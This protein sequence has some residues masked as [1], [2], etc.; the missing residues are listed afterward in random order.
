M[1][2]KPYDR[3]EQSKAVDYFF[4]PPSYCLLTG[5]CSKVSYTITSSTIKSE[6]MSCREQAT[7]E[8][9]VLNPDCRSAS[10]TALE[11]ARASPLP[12]I[13][14]SLK[15]QHNVTER[16]EL[17]TSCGMYFPFKQ[18]SCC[19]E[20]SQHAKLLFLSHVYFALHPQPQWLLKSYC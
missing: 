10:K 6:G 9:L 15:R 17:L 18:P 19:W 20:Q 16:R 3:A 13:Q 8:L 5:T 14:I 1:I 7:F 4:K 11:I 12:L 2:V